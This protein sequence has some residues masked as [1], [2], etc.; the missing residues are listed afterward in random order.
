M[1]TLILLDDVTPNH[2]TVTQVIEC[3]DLGSYE[4]TGELRGQELR[5]V[6]N[7]PP[8]K[9]ERVRRARFPLFAHG[10]RTALATPDRYWFE[11]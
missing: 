8:A 6:E 4:Y 1:A 9:G 10:I 5:V 7:E 3:D 11:R 2:G